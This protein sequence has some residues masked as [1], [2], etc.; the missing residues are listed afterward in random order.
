MV[1]T[2]ALPR[3]SSSRKLSICA[4]S[5]DMRAPEFFQRL[6]RAA[7]DFGVA[8]LLVAAEALARG[9]VERGQQVEG[10]VGGLIIRG[11]GAGDVLAKRSQSGGARERSRLLAQC[12]R[13]RVLACH[14]P[15]GDGFHVAFDAGN[16]PGE[17]NSRMRPQ[18]QRR[19][20]Q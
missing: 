10:D 11:I 20:Q 13:R 5:S 9:L 14:Q 2:E 7:A 17:K 12:Q 8:R 1:W 6:E 16:L 15:R 4:E 18:L 3:W 19:R